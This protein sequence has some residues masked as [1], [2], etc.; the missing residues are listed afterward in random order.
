MHKFPTINFIGNKEKIAKWIVDYFPADAKTLLDAFSGGS[1]V[2]YQAKMKGLQ[3]FSNDIL[4]INYLLATSF[5]ENNKE[6]LSYKDTEI[7]FAGTPKEGFMFNHY[8]EV[9][10]FPKECKELDLYRENIE[11]LSSPYKKAIAFAMLRRAMIRK[12]PYSRFNLSWQ[13]I[14]D[15]RNETLSYQKYKR[16][17]AYHNQSF[18]SLFLESWHEYNE[19]VFDNGQANKAYNQDIFEL[20]PTIQADIIYLDPPYTGTMNNY[21]EFYG[22]IDEYIVGEKLQPFQ[23]N[24][25]EKKNSIELFDRLFSTLGNYKY[26]FLSYNNGAYPTKENLFELLAKYG[27]NVKI[28]EK[29][30]IYKIT[31]KENKNENIEYL[32]MAENPLFVSKQPTPQRLSFMNYHRQ[33]VFEKKFAKS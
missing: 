23:N 26:W 6:K 31:G 4:K 8:A 17:R 12:M 25:I 22:M 19:T 30:H 10:Y 11:L 18:K 28:V 13:N 3:V 24:F 14:V 29:P 32:F 33:E 7:I 5:I 27:T 2:S 20:L 1:S 21:F 15:L 9:F 16:A